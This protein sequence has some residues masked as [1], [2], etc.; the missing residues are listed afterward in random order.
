MHLYS[1]AGTLTKSLNG[2][3]LG[4]SLACLAVNSDDTLLASAVGSSLIIFN[5][6]TNT[7][8]TLHA[9]GAR[10]QT[11]SVLAFAPSR[12]TFLAA[13]TST[14]L[15]HLFDT[16][17]PSA[18]LRTISLSSSPLPPAVSNLA[19]STFAPLLLVSSSTGHLSL[20]DTEKQKVIVQFELGA[21]VEKGKMALAP[22]GRTAAFVGK[23]LVRLLDIKTRKG[24][25]E[26]KIE[27]GGRLEGIAFQVSSHLSLCL[28]AELRSSPLHSRRRA[29]LA[30]LDL[31][32]PPSPPH[33]FSPSQSI[34]CAPLSVLHRPTRS[35]R[36]RRTS[37][38]PLPSSTASTRSSLPF[39]SAGPGRIKS[40][41]SLRIS[42]VTR[43]LS[44]V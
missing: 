4:A 38:S 27:G 13:A 3:S 30:P 21:A 34:A 33:P 29:S 43:I 23:G 11:Y 18:P 12:R 40:I 10:A 39:S 24:C 19:F 35:K 8:N 20:V 14:G 16:S 37:S 41:S 6:T 17:K 31:P 26:V 28:C 36:R 42:L 7:Q 25:K 32:R 44:L 9:K 15:V 5:R 2:H 1:S 22:D